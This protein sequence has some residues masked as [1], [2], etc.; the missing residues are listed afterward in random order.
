MC[1]FFKAG[2]WAERPHCP[3]PPRKAMEGDVI[4]VTDS[5]FKANSDEMLKRMN[6]CVGKPMQFFEIFRL[7]F[8][9]LHCYKHC[10]YKVH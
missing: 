1:R 6:P 5:I 2:A 4:P 7:L 8:G 9:L 3:T 10:K